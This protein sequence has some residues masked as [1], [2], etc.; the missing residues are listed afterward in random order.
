MK[1]TLFL[2]DPGHGGMKDGI[3]QTEGKRSP[4]WDDGT[5]LFEGEFNRDIVKRIAELAPM[6]EVRCHNLVIEEDDI[7]LGE[8][9]KRAN[10]I[11]QDAPNIQCVY[12]S[13]HANAGGGQGIEVFTSPGFTRADKMADVFI[14]KLG[15]ISSDIRTRTDYSD[16][17]ADKEAN[18]Y[19]LKK[20]AMPAVLTENF[21]MDNE[22]ECKDYLMTDKGRNFIALAHIAAMLKIQAEV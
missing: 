5:Q 2:L 15:S 4:I 19:V 7:S 9:V 16:G 1:E 6:F 17:D 21:F 8:R 18:F 14:E 13:V 11:H 12:V 10:A 3:Y 20:T 22:Q